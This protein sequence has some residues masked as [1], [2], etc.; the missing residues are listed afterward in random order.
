MTKP[1]PKTISPV[2]YLIK[3][4]QSFGMLKVRSP[5]NLAIYKKAKQMENDLRSNEIKNTFLND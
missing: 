4:L 5:F 3:E 1:K 2:D